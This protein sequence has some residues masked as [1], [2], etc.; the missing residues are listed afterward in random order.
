MVTISVLLTLRLPGVRSLKEKRAIVRSLA[1]RLRGRLG[2]SAAE[3][4]AQDRPQRALVGFAV[5]SGDLAAARALAG[6]AQRFAEREL[7]GRAEIVG[8]AIEE[9]VIGPGD[10]YCEGPGCPDPLPP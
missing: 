9:T 10:G 7:L 3:T 5:V 6:E 1:A 8:R 2:L 4:G